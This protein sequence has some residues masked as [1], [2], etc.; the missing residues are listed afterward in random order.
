[1]EQVVRVN[2]DQKHVLEIVPS[3]FAGQRAPWHPYAVSEKPV[4][5]AMSTREH[6]EKH[7]VGRVSKG[8]VVYFTRLQGETLTIMIIFIGQK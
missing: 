8:G 3:E 5:M 7:F 6:L 4:A 2:Q 1:M